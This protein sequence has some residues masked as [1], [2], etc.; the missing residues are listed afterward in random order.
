MLTFTV[1]CLIAADLLNEDRSKKNPT[2]IAC[3][4]F[5]SD[6][7]IHPPVHREESFFHFSLTTS[8][9]TDRLL[10]P[11]LFLLTVCPVPSFVPSSS[12]CPSDPWDERAGQVPGKGWCSER[13]GGRGSPDSGA[14]VGARMGQTAEDSL[15]ARELSA[16]AVFSESELRECIRRGNFFPFCNGPGK[17]QWYWG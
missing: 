12:P 11:F 16:V 4:V 1:S 7:I 15:E 9:P 5:P 13:L 17:M 6:I 14:P 10:V 2:P 8:A 3:L